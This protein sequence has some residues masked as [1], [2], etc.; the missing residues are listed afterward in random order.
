MKKIIIL[1]LMLCIVRIMAQKDKKSTTK[2]S[3]LQK[4]NR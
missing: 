3:Y 4:E 1:V 2:K